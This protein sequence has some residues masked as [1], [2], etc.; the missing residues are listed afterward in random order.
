M[1]D[2]NEIFALRS[3]DNVNKYLD[4]KPCKSI[5][6]AKNFILMINENIQRNDSIYWA[7]TLNGTDKIIGTICLFKFYKDFLKA[8][9]GYELLP[10]FQGKG[11]M[12]EAASIVIH[13]A[14]QHVGLN[15]I[16]AFTHNGNENSTRLLEKLNFKKES[17]AGENF[18]IFK[19]SHNG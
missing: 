19:L 15:S 12:Q 16:D 1:S 5:D 9:I 4:R 14:F 7:I 8:E 3:N 17:A 11:I 2:Q 6:D 18:M 13:F 10:E